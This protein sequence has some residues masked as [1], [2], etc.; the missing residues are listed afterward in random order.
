MK[1]RAVPCGPR[2]GPEHSFLP[3]SLQAALVTESAQKTSLFFPLE[4]TSLWSTALKGD[5]PRFPSATGEF[6]FLLDGNIFQDPAQN[7]RPPNLPTPIFPGK[8]AAPTTGSCPSAPPSTPPSVWTST[9]PT[10]SHACP[11]LSGRENHEG[12]GCVLMFTAPSWHKESGDHQRLLE[13]QTSFSSD[14]SCGSAG[15][16]AP[17]SPASSH[18]CPVLC[19][20]HRHTHVCITA[21]TSAYNTCLIIGKIEAYGT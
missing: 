19:G 21:H 11:P 12:R 5:V 4:D 3:V 2:A 10:S 1:P 13:K 17:N 7:P 15:S 6:H 18:S 8:A 14:G 9:M 20:A 16:L